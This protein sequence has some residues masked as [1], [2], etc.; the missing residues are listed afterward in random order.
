VT[1]DRFRV[2]AE[3]L[4]HPEGVAWDPRGR[5]IAG[6]EAGQVYAVSLEGQVREVANTGGFLLGLALDAAGR[7]YACD[8]GRHAVVRVDPESGEVTTYSSG[9]PEA[10]MRTPNYPAFA[11]DGSLY[12]TDSGAW[13]A[14]DGLIY[15]VRPGGETEVWTREPRSFPNGCCLAPDGEMLLVVQS[16]VPGLFRVPI[17]GDGSAGS[18]ELVAELSV[19]PDGVCVATDGTILVSCYRPDR[20]YAL[21]PGGAPEVLVE[22]PAGTLIAAP[23]NVAFGGEDL[24]V[25]FVASLGRWHLTRGQVGLRGVPLRYPDLG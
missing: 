21:R 3:G 23:T 24:D 2:L 7:I 25:L 6:G 1:L 11:A 19:V 14:T 17:L 22:D 9:T 20:I 18:P 16:T 12:V 10:P 13:K 4:D 8:Q 5:V 15:R